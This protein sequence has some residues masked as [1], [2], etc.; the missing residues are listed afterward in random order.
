ME[1][2]MKSTYSKRNGHDRT[3]TQKKDYSPAATERRK[4]VLKRLENQILT[5]FKT[6][7]ITDEAKG[8]VGTIGTEPLSDADKKRIQREIEVLK[9]RI[10]GEVIL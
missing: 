4:K 1:V 10:K 6:C 9:T 7:L 3:R 5:G 8:V 2:T